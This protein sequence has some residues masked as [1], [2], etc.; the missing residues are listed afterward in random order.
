MVAC[1]KSVVLQTKN[2]SV[3]GIDENPESL[4]CSS[5]LCFSEIVLS[6]GTVGTAGWRAPISERGFAPRAVPP[7]ALAPLRNCH[8]NNNHSKTIENGKDA[9]ENPHSL[10]MRWVSFSLAIA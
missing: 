10:N 1:L 4:S 8:P 3:A 7:V 2:V 9:K 5:L 6:R